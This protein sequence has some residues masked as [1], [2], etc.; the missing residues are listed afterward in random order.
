MCCFW[1]LPFLSPINFG[2]FRLVPRRDPGPSGKTHPGLEL[3]RHFLRY[4]DKDGH[5]HANPVR[6]EGSLKLSK[7]QRLYDVLDF[8]VKII[9]TLNLIFEQY[10]NVVFGL[11]VETRLR[12]KKPRHSARKCINSFLKINFEVT[13]LVSFGP[14]VE[15]FIRFICT[16]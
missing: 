8:I 11:I 6:T 4:K 13:F 12:E 10:L 14:T 2:S 5:A 9:I 1:S 16:M 3:L 15:K 7:S